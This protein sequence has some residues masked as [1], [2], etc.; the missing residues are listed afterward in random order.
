MSTLS[1]RPA[2]HSLSLAIGVHADDKL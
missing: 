1:L 2:F